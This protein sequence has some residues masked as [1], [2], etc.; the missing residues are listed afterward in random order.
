HFRSPL[1]E[2]ARREALS[3]DPPGRAVADPFGL[4]LTRDEQWMVVS[5]SGTHELLVLRVADLPLQDVGGTDHL[6]EELR[7]APD[8]FDRI[9]VGGR[10]MGLC[11]ADDD[12][13]IYVANYLHNSVQVV[14]RI[15]KKLVAEWPLGGPPEPSLARRGEAIFYDAT[16]SLD[17][18]Y[19]CHSCHYQGGINAERM[20]TENDGSRFTF[21]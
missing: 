18:W 9:V 4:R 15:E 11:I 16:R 21:K 19:S 6:P 3:L 2:T 13:T 20:D 12:R 10:P 7:E 1:G 8:R 5:A 14:D 17:Q